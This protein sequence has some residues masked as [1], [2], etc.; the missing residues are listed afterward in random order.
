MSEISKQASEKLAI[1]PEECVIFEMR[2]TGEKVIFKETD[3][4]II[5]TLS[6]NGR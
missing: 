3:T 4:C 2:S 1:S 5:T 6:H